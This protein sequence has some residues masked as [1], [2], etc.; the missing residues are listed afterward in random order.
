MIRDGTA[1][2]NEAANWLRRIIGSSEGLEGPG[3]KAT[4]KARKDGVRVL[5]VKET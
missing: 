5:R 2:K 3:F 4:N 1:M